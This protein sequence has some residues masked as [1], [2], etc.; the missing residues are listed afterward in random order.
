[1]P[2]AKVEASSAVAVRAAVVRAVVVRAVVARAAV[3]VSVEAVTAVVETAE[4]A[5][6]AMVAPA[7]A[8]A[9]RMVVVAT[10]EAMAVVA[11]VVDQMVVVATAAE[12]MVV[13]AM[14]AEAMVVVAMVVEAMVVVAM[15][16]IT[17]GQTVDQTVE[18]AA[19]SSAAEA[20][21]VREARGYAG[22]A[23]AES[24]NEDYVRV[25]SGDG[26][27]CYSTTST[28]RRPRHSQRKLRKA[29]T[30]E[31][32]PAARGSR[33][34]ACSP[35]MRRGSRQPWQSSSP[36]PRRAEAV[37]AEAVSDTL[38]F[39]RA[40]SDGLAGRLRARARLES[41]AAVTKCPV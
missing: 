14:V 3:G 28:G 22:D 9:E 11:T 29:S 35:C 34:T 36:E 6:A 2:A 23:S 32:W 5:M 33:G 15:V 26:S 38:S 10:V 40:T 18:R 21:D 16:A 7:A 12:A 1:M 8:K 30:M 25:A 37:R 27:P 41:Q 20:D 13:V 4:A 17:A 19:E 39:G 24:A 31:V